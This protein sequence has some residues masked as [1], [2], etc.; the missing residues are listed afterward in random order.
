MQWAED[1]SSSV[2]GCINTIF[3]PRVSLWSVRI[4]LVVGCGASLAV[5]HE[6]DATT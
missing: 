6:A 5:R 4:T 3:F 2:F 1:G